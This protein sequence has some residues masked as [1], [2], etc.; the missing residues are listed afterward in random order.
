MMVGIT[1]TDFSW[2]LGY[3]N[4]FYQLVSPNP[5]NI[6][7][8][9]SLTQPEGGK[10]LIRFNYKDSG[11]GSRRTEVL[12]GFGVYWGRGLTSMA[13][14]NDLTF[15]EGCLPRISMTMVMPFD[16]ASSAVTS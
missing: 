14:R 8:Y 4:E 11:D 16:L 7:L 3:I 6:G 9:G 5:L 1:A 10:E 12:K 2:Y 13:L 15:A